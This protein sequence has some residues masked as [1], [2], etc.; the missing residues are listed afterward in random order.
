[1]GPAAHNGIRARRLWTTRDPTI[2]SNNAQRFWRCV[3]EVLGRQIT[4]PAGQLHP[5]RARGQPSSAG[6]GQLGIA[7][8]ARSNTAAPIDRACAI[9]AP[10]G[11]GHVGRPSPGDHPRMAGPATAN[12]RPLQEQAVLTCLDRGSRGRGVRPRG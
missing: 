11:L 8:R 2:R 9:A 6:L 1:M 5:Q 12:S 4:I 7:E 3:R 10:L